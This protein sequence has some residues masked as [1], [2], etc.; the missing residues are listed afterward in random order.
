ML[1][2]ALFPHPGKA[3]E[4]MGQGFKHHGVAVPVSGHRGTVATVDGQGHDVVLSWLNDYRGGYQL[5]LIDA[6]TG[7]TEDHALPFKPGDYP[8][9][10]ILSTSNKFYTH[11]NS[12]FIEFDPVKRAFTFSRE[13]M[14]RMAMSMTEDD[15]GVIWSAT[16]PDSG[17][18]SFNPRTREF[19][20]HGSLN[21]ENWLQ[22]P[23][24]LAADDA[25]WIYMSI[26]T[27]RGQLVMFNPQ[28]AKATALLSDAERSEWYPGATRD[29]DGRV[30]VSPKPGSPDK[31]LVLYKGQA[32]WTNP[33]A[34]RRPKTYIAGSQGLFHDRFPSGKRIKNFDLLNRELV[35]EDAKSGAVKALPFDYQ[36]EGASVMGLA[37][38]PDGT[39]CGGTAFPMRFFSFDPRADKWIHRDAFGK[40]WNTIARQGDRFFIGAYTGG[41]LLEW[42]PAA[43][44]A[45]ASPG[46]T[47]GNP[48][49]LGEAK[50]AI[51]RPHRLFAHPDGKTIVMGGTP[52][53]GATGGG[54]LFWDRET[55]QSRLLPHEQLLRDHATM[56][57]VPLA[58]DKLLGG[59]TTAPG[60][61]GE[62]KAKAAELYILDLRTLKVEWH[63]PGLPD[64]QE[65][66]D[67]CTA[68]NGLVFG[69]ADAKRFFVFDPAKREVVHTAANGKQLGET[70]S[71]QGPRVF[72]RGPKETI[73]VLLRKGIARLDPATFKLTLLAESPVRIGCGGDYLD[74]RIYFG[75]GSHVYSWQVPE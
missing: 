40:Q 74:G 69:F 47:K 12:H 25:G 54:L 56:S 63:A 51:N 24:N 15:R 57:L 52:A 13:T 26:G 42:D 43:P 65:Y 71:G 48:Q 44:W 1:A 2:I 33:P 27:T 11:F 46:K 61:G 49:L 39:L 5:L 75:N 60:T 30:Y 23:R 67:L 38:A 9:A 66:T 4:D 14:P 20:D 6:T 50:P 64:V 68:P 18:V 10:S 62:K 58:G 29:L 31:W 37:A 36:S 45:E 19:K 7:R 41:D 35:I 32:T 34:P 16:Y 3:A 8:Y 73:Y 21:K 17:L 53:Y 72:V 28:T 22:Y 70:S 59:T 55:R